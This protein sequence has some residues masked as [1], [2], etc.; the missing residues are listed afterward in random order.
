MDRFV[1]TK[2]KVTP[3]GWVLTD[4]QN[5]IVLT[6]EKHRFNDTQKVTALNDIDMP[7]AFKLARI[8]REM[9]DYIVTH[10]PDLCF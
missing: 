6:F 7:D 3:N 10:Y 5:M 8:M 1:L 4:T 9:G 2:S